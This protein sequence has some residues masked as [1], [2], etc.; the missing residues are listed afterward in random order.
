MDQLDR[1]NHIRSTVTSDGR[2]RVGRLAKQLRVSEMTVRRDLD[3]LAAS[4]ELERVRGGATTAG[5]Q[6]FTARYGRGSRAKQRIATKLR[7]LVDDTDA[8]GI[9]AS[10]T[11]QR[12]AVLLHDARDV[13]AITNG[14]DSFA[15]LRTHRG[16]TALLTGGRLDPRTGS[17][18]GPLATRAARD[19]LLWRFFTSAAGIDPAHGT[20][21]ATL[22]EAEV[23]LAFAD[24]AKELVVAVDASK[25][26]RRD[27]A[28]CVPIERIDV[29]VTDLAP[30]D[31]R[32]D[33]YR[34]HCRDIR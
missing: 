11:L 5:P 19:M 12:L 10:S 9:D 17:L 1:L 30:D 29:L 16:V 14:P 3:L 18:V 31:A 26:G 23:K 27:A 32:L 22:E 2:V 33:P 25:L 7:A 28:R 6:P 24:V 20:T 4:G 21:E 8:I 13:T 15:S 34:E